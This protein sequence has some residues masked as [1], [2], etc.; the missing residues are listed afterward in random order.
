MLPPC[1]FI[2]VAYNC[3]ACLQDDLLTA[4]TTA[5]WLVAGG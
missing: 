5:G 1:R 3:L 4:T 2:V